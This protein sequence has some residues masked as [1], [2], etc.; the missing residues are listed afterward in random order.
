MARGLF[1]G[2]GA[3]GS[4]FRKIREEKKQAI[5]QRPELAP[6]SPERKLVKSPVER[7]VPEGSAKMVAV[8]PTVTQIAQD[9]QTPTERGE[10]MGAVAPAAVGAQ[11][12]VAIAKDKPV[13]REVARN[14]AMDVIR[15]GVVAGAATTPSA[16]VPTYT[17]PTT[18]APE[19]IKTPKKGSILGA[20]TQ[21]VPLREKATRVGTVDVGRPVSGRY[22][23][24]QPG[25]EE[26]V[27]STANK[28]WG[29]RFA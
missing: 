14:A 25:E 4:K 10:V 23:V 24:G 16:Q 29:S 15:E 5:G 8:R 2:R 3:V 22:I 12:A 19:S 20:R 27:A 1:T 13:S 18:V 9:V 6:S 17:A 11:G 28:W 26:L 7:M 21:D